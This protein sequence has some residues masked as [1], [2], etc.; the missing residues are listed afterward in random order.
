M[1][2]QA[3][4][5]STSA[6]LSFPFA[7]SPRGHR[8][9]LYYIWP[10]DECPRGIP[11]QLP[12]LFSFEPEYHTARQG[13]DG[14]EGSGVLIAFT[15]QQRSLFTSSLTTGNAGLSLRPYA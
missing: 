12:V 10:Y 11:R 6:L 13:L 5:S 14:D 7:V 15:I 4:S 9:G 2:D 8:Y 1:D 3:I